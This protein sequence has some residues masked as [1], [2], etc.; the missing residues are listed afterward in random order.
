MARFSLAFGML[1]VAL[2]ASAEA[3]S[4][5]PPGYQCGFVICP[6]IY[7]PVCGSDWKTYSNQCNL[8]AA[9]CRNPRLRLVRPGKC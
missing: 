3:R 4:P 9:K 8:E 2:M 6:A 5:V 7:A 1:V